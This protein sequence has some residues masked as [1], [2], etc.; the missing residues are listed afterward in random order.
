MMAGSD[1]T[2]QMRA[3][4]GA[5]VVRVASR[6]GGLRRLTPAGM[7]ALLCA[8]AFGPILAPGMLAVGGAA[9]LAGV[10]VLSSVGSNVLADVLQ[11]ALRRVRNRGGLPG[12]EEIEDELATAVE[13]ALSAGDAV[14]VGLRAEIAAVLREIDGVGA[15]LEAVVATGDERIQTQLTAAFG[16]LTEEFA[17]FGFVLA[18]VQAVART[19]QQTL[20]RQDA[21]Y[22][23]ERDRARQLSLQVR[24]MREELAVIERRTRSGG[25]PDGDRLP[26]WGVRWTAGSPYRGLYPFEQ[27]HEGVFYGRERLTAQLL[28]LAGERLTGLGLVMVTGAS[29]AG[30]SSLLRAGFV[31]AVARG[32]LTAGS[33]DWPRVVMTPTRAPLDELAIHLAE[34]GH[35]EV[36]PVRAALAHRPDQAHL[37]VRHVLQA[38][39]GNGPATQPRTD[40]VPGRLVA[41]MI[42]HGCGVRVGTQIQPAYSATTQVPSRKNHGTVT[43]PEN[44]CHNHAPPNLEI[45]E[46]LLNF[47][48]A[49]LNRRGTATRSLSPFSKRPPSVGG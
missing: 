15:A 27:D 17:E 19:V 38:A 35:L 46:D 47:V 5:R 23:A 48:V 3:G 43:L 34:V 2:E 30:K 36:S 9:A 49:V 37:L 44:P 28:G 25:L 40:P 10:T 45:H 32:L 8:G 13:N 21:E 29:G 39:I 26:G 33:E 22:R 14:A 16:A 42:R 7:L 12:P 31:P 11:R 1:E 6:V 41:R 4:V 24:L 20:W 18:D